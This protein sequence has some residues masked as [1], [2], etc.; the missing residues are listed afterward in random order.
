[1]SVKA[2]STRRGIGIHVTTATLVFDVPNVGLR[3]TVHEHQPDEQQENRQTCQSHECGSRPAPDEH[4][5]AE[6]RPEEEHDAYDREHQVGSIVFVRQ[7][8]PRYPKRVMRG[9]LTGAAIAFV[10][11]ALA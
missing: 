1:M 3:G 11:V 7:A 9:A 8:G 5:P 10:C 4:V 6:L 2:F